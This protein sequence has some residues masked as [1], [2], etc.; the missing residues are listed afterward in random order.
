MRERPFIY[1]NAAQSA[2]GKL[3]PATRQ[4]EPFGSARDAALVY[5]L[6]AQAD[7]IMC[8]ARTV[9]GQAITL[10]NGGERYE[11]RRVKRGRS[12]Y[13]LRVIVSGTGS[14]SPKAEVFRHD[15]SPIII[16]TSGRAS[17][18][19]LG[20][21]ERLASEVKVCGKER[22]DLRRAVEWLGERWGVRRLLCEGGGELNGA[23][24]EAGLVDEVYV[25][26]CPLILG[27]RTAPTL[28]DGRGAERLAGATELELKSARRHG[29]EMFLCYKVRR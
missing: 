1:L 22:V 15:F 19:S 7:A 26:M 24:F 20:R 3:A 18:R 5:E 13:P 9:D 10:G 6:R 11:R 28:A 23:L 16:V 17:R 21:L 25:T 14:I 12:R 27:G 8:G 4:Y 2:D 29:D